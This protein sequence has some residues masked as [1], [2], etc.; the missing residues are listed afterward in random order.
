MG[1]VQ[2]LAAFVGSIA[3]LRLFY[4]ITKSNANPN[5]LPF[6]PG[7]KGLPIIGN[8]LDIPEEKMWITADKWFQQ[9]GDIVYYKVFGQGLLLLGSLE[10]TRDIYEKC[11][12]IYSSRR[13][14]VMLNELSGGSLN[15][16]LQPYG[17][18]WRQH[19][20]VFHEYFNLTA[21]PKYRATQLKH[22]R[23]LL[24][25]LLTDAE[26]SK[27][28]NNLRHTFA[29]LLLD[30]THGYKVADSDDPLIE[31]AEISFTALSEGAIPGRFLVDSVPLLKYVP[32]WFP[33]AGFKRLAKEW[34]EATIR[35]MDFP[36]ETVK[37]EL[38]SRSYYQSS[39]TRWR[40]F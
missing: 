12:S 13:Q 23:A 1:Y 26:S 31:A 34:K 29:A 6:P 11:S 32:V 21:I 3:L 22:A 39:N 36:F 40:S 33:G 28:L 38:V 19:R 20:R 9:Y 5:K 2:Y 18:L 7:P 17:P 25:K 24:L 35:M 27:L 4:S 14:P 15:F 37:E 10:R 30:V 8:L 16:G